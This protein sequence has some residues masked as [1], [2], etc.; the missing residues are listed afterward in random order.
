[1]H[2]PQDDKFSFSPSPTLALRIGYRWILPSQYF[3]DWDFFDVSFMSLLTG[4]FGKLLMDN[5]LAVYGIFSPACGI[6]NGVFSPD[7]T[8]GFGIGFGTSCQITK[9]AAFFTECRVR[10]NY[11]NW[12]GD[13]KKFTEKAQSYRTIYGIGKSGDPFS[14]VMTHIV[15][16]F[17]FHLQKYNYSKR[18]PR[19]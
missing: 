19:L 11:L 7:R 2:S 4:K 9:N 3:I 5:K 14:A 16:G 15:I 6:V 8:L 18:T 12:Y 10:V 17:Q 1:M 13:V